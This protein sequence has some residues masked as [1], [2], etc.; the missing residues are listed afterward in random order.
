VGKREGGD[1]SH[2]TKKTREEVRSGRG[3]RRRNSQGN[4]K[5]GSGSLPWST[6]LWEDSGQAFLKATSLAR[7]RDFQRSPGDWRLSFIK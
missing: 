1:T 4:R 2:S 6:A 5:K 7:G 3:P